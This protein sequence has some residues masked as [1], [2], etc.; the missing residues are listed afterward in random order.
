LSTEDVIKKDIWEAIGNKPWARKLVYF[1]LTY[2]LASPV[3]EAFGGI[4]KVGHGIYSY[5]AV[6]DI[7]PTES[8]KIISAYWAGKDIL[9]PRSLYNYEYDYNDM[10]YLNSYRERITHLGCEAEDL[11]YGELKKLNILDRNERLNSYRAYVE[12]CIKNKNLALFHLYSL[13]ENVYILEQYL[14]KKY[15]DKFYSEPLDFQIDQ[16]N[17]HWSKLAKVNNW[18]FLPE[19]IIEKPHNKEATEYQSAYKESRKLLKYELGI[20]M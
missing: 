18:S 12:G 6:D 4:Y 15:N 20:V 19:K 11:S 3:F 1:S 10:S 13:G 9:S 17:K 14:F 5:F 7:S 8:E 2:T 16:M